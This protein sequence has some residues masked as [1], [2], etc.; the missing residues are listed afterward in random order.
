MT[1]INRFFIKHRIHKGLIK[2]HNYQLNKLP[3]KIIAKISR[4]SLSVNIRSVNIR[5]QKPC[6]NHETKGVEEG[7]HMELD[8][9]VS[10]LNRWMKQGGWNAF[11]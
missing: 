9:T 2:S 10:L 7:F 11:Q 5:Y 3:F 6:I 1:I 4:K 8:V